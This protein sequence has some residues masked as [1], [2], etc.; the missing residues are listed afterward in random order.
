MNDPALPGWFRP[1]HYASIGSTNDAAKEFAREGAPAG[2]LV[3]ADQQTA[4]R[5]RRGRAWQSP[6]GNLYL[7]LVLRPPGPPVRAA[8][9]GF[10][11][12]L[13]LSD[14]LAPYAV[15]HEL[16]CKW[17]NDVLLDGS[18]IAGILLESETGGGNAVEFVILGMGVNLVAAPDVTE[19]PAISLKAAGIVPPSPGI[20]LAAFAGH[21]DEWHRRWEGQGFAPIRRAWLDRASGVGQTIRVRLERASFTGRFLD[22][23]E[24]G[25]L[26]LDDAGVHRRIAAGEVFPA[27]TPHRE[28]SGPEGSG[29]EGR[30]RDD[31]AS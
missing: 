17:P 13:A 4:G 14:A 25:G 22:I 11:A 3:W 30:G 8:Q 29:G 15:T 9:L 20:A 26:L 21:F 1:V 23:D 7:S 24:E 28:E 5:G 12:A 16:R 6:P 27:A 31:R 10:V 18:K 19:F 2:T